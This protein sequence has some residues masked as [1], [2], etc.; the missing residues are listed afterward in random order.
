MRKRWVVF[1]TLFCLA[2]IPLYYTLGSGPLDFDFAIKRAEYQLSRPKPDFVKAK[3]A[4]E[5]AERALEKLPAQDSRR[6]RY[7]LSAASLAWSGGKIQDADRHFRQSYE[8][9]TACHGPNSWHTSAVN[10]RYAEFLMY[11]RRF[12]EAMK[13]FDQGTR[14]IDEVQGPNSAF[15][16]RMNCRKVMLLHNLGRISESAELAK[17]ILPHLLAQA[18]L[19][20][21]L[22]LRQ[23]A[24]T[25][26]TLSRQGLLQKT[27]KRGWANT[28]VSAARQARQRDTEGEAGE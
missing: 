18:N 7:H 14:A 10:L 25:L 11:C 28:L 27:G 21:E 3:D 16:I 1:Y 15:A 8:I 12:P 23:V 20:D 4:L 9:F 13:R 2:Q 24:G 17:E 22:M 19:F 6:A 5:T 26:D